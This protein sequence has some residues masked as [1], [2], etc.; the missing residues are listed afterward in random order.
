ML[1][2]HR[3]ELKESGW[4]Q[5]KKKRLTLP[6]LPVCW[7]GGGGGGH[8]GHQKSPAKISSVMHLS[9][10]CEETTP[11]WCVQLQMGSPW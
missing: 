6:S 7:F 5:Q 8:H 9:E 1:V 10:F 4:C 2:L 3:A 11:H